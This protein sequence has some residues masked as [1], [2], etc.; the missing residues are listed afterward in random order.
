MIGTCAFYLNLLFLKL[1]LFSFSSPNETALLWWSAL[2][3]AILSALL[4]ETLKSRSLA[5]LL[6]ELFKSI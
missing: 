4:G 5:L 1:K 6:M 2:C 3:Y